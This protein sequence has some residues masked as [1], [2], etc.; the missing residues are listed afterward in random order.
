M[1]VCSDTTFLWVLRA[2]GMLEAMKTAKAMKAMKAAKPMKVLHTDNGVS[3]KL[4]ECPASFKP[5]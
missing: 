3:F 4:V 2:F 5:T 1:L